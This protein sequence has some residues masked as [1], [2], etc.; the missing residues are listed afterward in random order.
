MVRLLDKGE[1]Q[2]VGS[3]PCLNLLKENPLKEQLFLPRVC[4]AP[5]EAAELMAQ[6]LDACTSHGFR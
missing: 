2:N 1:Y 3:L 4:F 6:V 5:I